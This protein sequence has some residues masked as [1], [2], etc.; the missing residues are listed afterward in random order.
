M[1]LRTSIHSGF[2]SILSVNYDL[3]RAKARHMR[4]SRQ[5]T[6][7]CHM[8]KYC[9]FLS[10]RQRFKWAGSL[11]RK[12]QSKE[13]VKKY[14]SVIGMVSAEQILNT[15]PK[16]LRPDKYKISKECRHGKNPSW[17]FIK[18]HITKREDNDT[19]LKNKI[20]CFFLSPHY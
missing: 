8:G 11:Q 3:Q 10:T 15:M 12:H 1:F 6:D 17:Y 9:C 5:N 13:A 2:S 18:R 14:P 20:V 16:I 19:Q 4:P 7:A